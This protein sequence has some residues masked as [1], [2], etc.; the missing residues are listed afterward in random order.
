MKKNYS[1]FCVLSLVFMLAIPFQT[2]ADDYVRGDV[3]E[4]G[5]VNISDVTTLIDYL[6]SNQWP[7]EQL[8]PENTDFTVGGVTFTMVYVEGG[9]FFM[10][11]TAEQ[12]NSAYSYEKPAHRVTLSSYYICST[13]VTQ[14]LWMEVMGANPSYFIGTN[15][16]VEHVDWY[17]CSSFIEKLNELTGKQFRMPTEAEWEFA[18][19]GGNKSHGYKFSGSSYISTVAWYKN[20]S[21][22]KTHPVATKTS[23]ELGLYDMSGNVWEWCSDWYGSYSGEQT[24]PTGPSTGTYHVNRGGGWNSNETFCRV[25]FREPNGS[26]SNSNGIIGLRLAMSY[27]N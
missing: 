4:D 20:N 5:I 19:R 25:S 15:L 18:A 2:A 17:A 12:G 1:F 10:G 8:Q 16:P 13:E 23:N 22:S 27:P 9:T 21:S 26:A 14:E 11:A 7:E 3:D 24:N 6:L